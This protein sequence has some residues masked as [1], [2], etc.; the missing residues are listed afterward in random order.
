MS[1]LG[2][3]KLVTT[4]QER[5]AIHIAVAP[6]TAAEKLVPGERIGLADG[7]ASANAV[8]IGIVDPYL[9]APVFAGQR[10]W[11]FLFPNTVTSLRHHWTHPAFNEGPQPPDEARPSELESAELWMTLFAKEAGMTR[12]EAIDRARDFLKDGWAWTE[13]GSETAR[14]A[15]F[16][17]SSPEEF[18]KRYEI[19]TGEVVGTHDRESAPFS[20]S[21]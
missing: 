20:C 21:C 11:L 4:E 6:V 10:F 9:Q 1:D 19:I 15:F 14:T 16:A 2:L 12:D 13:E 17:L 18:W 3:G 5:D 7:K 8:H